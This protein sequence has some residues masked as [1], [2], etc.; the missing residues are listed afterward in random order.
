MAVFQSLEPANKPSPSPWK[1]PKELTE[2]KQMDG[3]KSYKAPVPDP[4]TGLD[5]PNFRFLMLTLV[6]CH[7][8][9]LHHLPIHQSLFPCWKI[10]S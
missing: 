10:G 9:C 2:P 8:Q 3:G 6:S 1:A 4:A 7:L 5:L